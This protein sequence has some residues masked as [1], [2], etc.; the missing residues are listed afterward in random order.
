MDG[1]DDVAVLGVGRAADDHPVAVGVCGYSVRSRE[2]PAQKPVLSISS[3]GLE[4]TLWLLESGAY[5]PGPPGGREQGRY[6]RAVATAGR[7]YAAALLSSAPALAGGPAGT[8]EGLHSP[9]IAAT[10]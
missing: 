1:G 8:Q 3:D 4:M 2:D 6:D 5:S 9:R 10:I 7:I